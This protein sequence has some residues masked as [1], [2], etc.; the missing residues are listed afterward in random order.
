MDGLPHVGLDRDEVRVG[1]AVGVG[2]D[3]GDA[4]TEVL[5]PGAVPDSNVVVAAVDLVEGLDGVVVAVDQ[6][7][8]AGRDLHPEVHVANALA[9]GHRDHVV[10]GHVEL[11]VRAEGTAVAVG[12]VGDA[13]LGGPVRD[14]DDEV[15]NLVGIA[16][17]QV[18]LGRVRDAELGVAAAEEPGSEEGGQDRDE[19]L[20]HGVSPFRNDVVGFALP[21]TNGD[22]RKRSLCERKL[23]ASIS[24]SPD[25]GELIL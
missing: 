23:I 14:V 2:G 11:D 22:Q 12:H 15:V 19:L 24:V 16:H 13:D 5:E 21:S 6:A 4:V 10:P 17:A 18:R 1:L 8:A 20:G 3:S 25:W 9:I 7:R